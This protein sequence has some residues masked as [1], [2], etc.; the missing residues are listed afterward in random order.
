M[1]GERPT[2]ACFGEILWD[3]LPSGAFPGGAPFN[4]AYHLH[5]LG[6][7]VRLISA[8]G[9]DQLGNDLLERLANWG[10][11]TEGVNRHADRATGQVR[12]TL[13]AS[14]NAAYRIAPEAAWDRISPDENTLRAVDGAR[15]LVFGSL[16]QRSVEN[17]DALARLLA[18]LPADAWRVLDVNLRAPHDDLTLVL[19]LARRC[20]LLKLNAGE[21]ARLTGD[22]AGPGREEAH[23]RG[24]AA[25][26][27]C[28]VVCVT[29]GE[30]GAGILADG[31]WHWTEARPLNVR[32]TVGAGDAFTAGLLAGLLLHH[33]T[34]PAA[35]ERACRM[36][37]FVA[38]QDGATPAYQLDPRG[39][40]TSG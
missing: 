25:A 15:A 19:S 21:A 35:L 11:G 26:C 10:I 1:S 18:A 27:G 23:A 30:R 16:A 37:E 12:A 40:P 31:S 14:G 38:A 9:Q 4:V 7:R 29:A 34:P 33:E 39:G 8:I 32:D 5:R 28:A 17:R 2:V 36:G 22:Q 13:D 3:F 20:T 24:L 6:L